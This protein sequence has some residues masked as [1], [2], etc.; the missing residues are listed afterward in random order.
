MADWQ[1]NNIDDAII[2][3]Q[4]LVDNNIR[5]WGA[6]DAE[7][8]KKVGEQIPVQLAP[9][10][11]AQKL[12]EFAKTNYVSLRFSSSWQ[13]I[14]ACKTEDSAARSGASCSSRTTKEAIQPRPP[15]KVN[16]RPCAAGT[17][18]LWRIIANTGLQPGAARSG[19]TSR[20]F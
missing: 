5:I 6:T 16:T 20:C 9:R 7:E 17:I 10:K 12:P 19:E 8:F 3:L 18:S 15:S 4:F 2:L 11:P 14:A 1:R 13:K